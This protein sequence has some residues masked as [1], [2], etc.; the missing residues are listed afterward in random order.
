MSDRS[1]L[2]I[3]GAD[4]QPAYLRAKEA[5]LRMVEG[6]D[7]GPGDK[8]PSERT[9]S[10]SLGI[11][12]VTVRRSIEDLVR[13]GVLE[14]R[15]TSGTHVAT[16][17]VVRRLD[18]QRAMSVSQVVQTAGGQAGSRLLFFQSSLASRVVAGHLRIPVGAPLIVIRRLRSVNG[19]PFCVETSHLPA[20]RVPGLAAADLMGDVSL[21]AILQERYGIRVGNR[22]GVISVAP[23][24]SEDAALLDVQPGVNVLVYR[25]DVFD[26]QNRPIEHMVSINHPQRVS[27]TTAS[28]IHRQKT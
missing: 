7:Y 1:P 14:R 10:E 6:P 16:P 20:D 26:E 15:G 25:I 28:N 4:T 19:L 21:F 8:I 5:I 9:L 18:P 22:A 17:S 2:P 23:V 3:S 24:V 12:R 11:S 27:F 13:M